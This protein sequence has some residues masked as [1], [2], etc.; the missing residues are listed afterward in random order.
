MNLET[1]LIVG[2]IALCVISGT[3]AMIAM[4]EDDKKSK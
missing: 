2:F 1:F 3:V 4:K